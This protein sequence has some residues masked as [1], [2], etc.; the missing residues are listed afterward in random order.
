M[1]LV[2]KLIGLII[3][4]GFTSVIQAQKSEAQKQLEA[5][6]ESII[7]E[8]G[9]E[10]NSNILIED[11]EEYAINPLNINTATSNQLSRLHLMNDIQIYKLLEYRKALGPILSIY[12][13]NVVEGLDPEVLMRMEPFIWFG[14]IEQEPV[15]ITKI[16]KYGRHEMLLR[17]LGT[18]QMPRGNKEGE[19]GIVP[20]AGDRFRYYTRYRFQS[21]D[22][23]SAGITAEKDPGEAFFSGS[24][25]YGFDF[26]SAHLSVKINPV[27]QNITMGDFIVR[28]GQG[29]VLWQGFSMNKSLYATDVFKTNQGIRPYTSTDENR[30]FRGAA[31]SISIGDAKINF[32]ISKKNSDGNLASADSLNKHFTSL[33]TSGYHRT[34]NEIADKNSITDLN[35]GALGN[36]MFRNLKLGAVFI[37]RKFNMPFLPAEQLYNKFNFRGTE[38]FAGGIDYLFNKGKYL[39]FGESAIS[40]SGGKAVLQGATAYLHDRIQLSLL[41][42]HFNKNYHALW[43]A[44]FAENR[45][46][47]NETG[48]YSG[49]R[50][51]PVKHITFSAY[52]DSYHFEWLKYTT[53]GPS[54]GWDV[55]SQVDYRPSERFQLYFRYKNKE[56]EKKFRIDEKNENHT[57]QFRK[58]R[59][60]VQYIPSEIIALKTRIETVRYKG[61]KKENGIMIFQDA[62]VS[63]TRIPLNLSARIAW[64]NTDGYNSRIYAWENDLLYTF[65]IPAYYGDGYRLYI[66]MKYKMNKN[67]EMWL[68]LANF[69]YNNAETI[70]SGYNEIQG[71][72][73]TELKFQIRLKL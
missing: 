45:F 29:L 20:Y 60:H 65:A 71:N 50:I 31:T 14:P 69:F 37:Y 11:L 43:S 61:M 49:I 39:F 5:I 35:A 21:G 25:P 19:D 9:D 72:K 46:A 48:L 66:N 57:E 73:K 47:S 6:I 52:I 64:F 24:N 63:P 44:P 13:L 42:R 38:N 62:Q 68:K 34:K 55:F 28:S 7:E 26:Y 22:N 56:K 54:N 32:F 51:L 33:Q 40:K 16:L 3:L 53:A 12:E 17:S 41:F 1:K 10:T 4:T 15:N 70:G 18:V 23:I 2:F 30:F 36:I 58:N 59:I 27:I 67:V 8:Q